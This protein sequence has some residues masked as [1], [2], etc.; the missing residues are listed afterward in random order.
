MLAPFFDKTALSVLQNVRGL[1]YD[2]LADRLGRVHVGLR[3]SRKAAESVVGRATA[4]LA[5]NL[6]A[7]LYPTISI[8]APS[9]LEDELWTQVKE[10]NPVV[11]TG[12]GTPDVEI[13][14]G[15]S[16]SKA[17]RVYGVGAAGWTVWLTVGEG[18]PD[19]VWGNDPNVLAGAFGAAAAAA[20]V[21]RHVFQ[22]LGLAS[23]DRTRVL[24]LLNYDEP[25]GRGPEW[26]TP[27]LPATH[28]IGLGAV[29]N[30]AVWVLARMPLTGK[31]H[32]V[33]PEQIT[34]GN[35]QRYVLANMGLLGA[36]KSELAAQRFTKSQVRAVPHSKPFRDYAISHQSLDTMLIAVDSA[37]VRVQAQATLPRQIFNAWTD[38]DG[39]GVSSHLNFGGEEPCLACLY[40]VRQTNESDLHLLSRNVRLSLEETL[41]LLSSGNGLDLEQLRRVE[42][43]YAVEPGT[44]TPWTGVNLLKFREDVICG[45]ILTKLTGSVTADEDTLVPLAHQSVMAGVALAGE[46]LKRVMALTTPDY[47]G[48]FRCRVASSLP[49]AFLFAQRKREG[50]SCFCTDEDY[51]AVWKARWKQSS[52]GRPRSSL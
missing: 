35:V 34:L 10:I 50:E 40:K 14:V 29:G 20:S 23:D 39:L 13:V 52:R 8:H 27:E 46:Y 18:A 12:S 32:L 51:R 1:S 24:S 4:E 15:G 21:F 17:S 30:A 2:G 44:L 45:G 41:N 6:L 22:D 19:H 31:I 42:E 28:L 48:L 43:H 3:V 49:D 36:I 11:D 9:S 33:D 37:D 5:A 25:L 7:R 26:V 47:P 38:A 16:A